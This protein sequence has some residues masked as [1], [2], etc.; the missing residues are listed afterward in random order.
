[1]SCLCLA[2]ECKAFD[3]QPVSNLKEEMNLCSE[4]TSPSRFMAALPLVR[5]RF[6][7]HNSLDHSLKTHTSFGQS[8]A[9]MTFE[10]HSA[11]HDRRTHGSRPFPEVIC[12]AVLIDIPDSY[13][14]T[15]GKRV[16]NATGKQPILEEGQFEAEWLMPEGKYAT[17]YATFN[18]ERLRVLLPNT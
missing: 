14:P 12:L 9:D 15:G 18:N 17:M 2:D 7:T 8:F 13:C 5:L 16:A 4:K 3:I 10:V 11:L 6:H 1:M